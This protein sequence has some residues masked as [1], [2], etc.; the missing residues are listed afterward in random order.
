MKGSLNL[1]YRTVGISK[2]AV[3]DMLNRYM[4]RKESEYQVLN[5]VYK[6]RSNHP[7]M[8]VRQMYFKINPKGMGRDR[9]EHLCKSENLQL[10]KKKNY[11]KTT[12]SKGV[13]RFDNL[14][15]DLKV[16]RINQLWQSDIT[17]Y[18]INGR[19]YYITLIQDAFSKVIVGHHCSKSLRTED[20]TLPAFKKAIRKRKRSN[21]NGLIFHSDGGGQYYDKEFKKLTKSIGIINSMGESCYE[22]AMAESLN[23]V[24]KNKYLYH[25]GIKSFTQLNQKLDRVVKLYNTDK[26]HTKLNRMTPV[27]YEKI[28]LTSLS[29]TNATMKKSIDAMITKEGG[30]EP[31]SLVSNQYSKSKYHLCNEIS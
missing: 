28:Y 25:Y 14:I 10:K 21:I 31:P 30:I 18:E 23:G 24:I 19:F 9:F 7:T 27:Q 12:D 2:Q 17:Y 4:K 1:L 5:L 22:N 15:Q 3:H 13:T 8:G 29:Q 6:I 20:T 16:N 11:R 26:P